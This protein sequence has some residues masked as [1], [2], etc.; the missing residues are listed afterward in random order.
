MELGISMLLQLAS[1][2][3]E[4]S[5]RHSQV[6]WYVQISLRKCQSVVY[7]SGGKVHNGRKI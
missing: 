3:D 5:L 6:D 2:V 7:L 1:L 4:P